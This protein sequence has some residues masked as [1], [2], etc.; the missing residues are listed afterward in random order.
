[1][2]I[3]PHPNPPTDL[4]S[5]NLPRGEREFEDS[6]KFLLC[7]CWSFPMIFCFTLVATI[8]WVK[9]NWVTAGYFSAAIAGVALFLGYLMKGR[10]G[11]KS[12]E[13]QL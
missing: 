3:S 5:L 11:L 13:F 2:E 7:F 1:M 12:G 8:Y 4:A 9:M 6:E 10:N